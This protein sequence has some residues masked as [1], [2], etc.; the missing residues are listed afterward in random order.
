MPSPSPIP[1]RSRFVSDDAGGARLAVEHF[2]R[3]RA[4]SRIAHVTG[5]A[6]FAV[7]H[8][9]AEA[10]REALAERG[11]PARA[12][13]RRMV[14][15][16]GARGRRQIVRWQRRERPD[17]VFC[18][19]DQIARGVIDA[20]RERGIGCPTMS[21]SSASTIGRSWRRRPARR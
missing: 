21:A 15:S 4:A 2:C 14:G 3:A 9:R 7:V 5:P 19:N 10:Y 6:S 18:G 20:L 1:T 17:A 11:L 13:A 16:L 8:E 12:A